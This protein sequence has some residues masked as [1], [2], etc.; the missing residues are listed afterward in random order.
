[1]GGRDWERPVAD[2]VIGRS[3]PAGRNDDSRR[4]LV[5]GSLTMDPQRCH[6]S[7]EYKSH[8][9]D[10]PVF[11][12]KWVL[13]F[14]SNGSAANNVVAPN[15]NR[16]GWMAGREGDG[17]GS[18][19]IARV[20]TH[21][22]VEAS[23]GRTLRERVH[24]LDQGRRR[25]PNGF[26]LWNGGLVMDLSWGRKLTGGPSATVLKSPKTRDDSLI[27]HGEHWNAW[28]GK[29]HVDSAGCFVEKAQS[30]RPTWDVV[31]QETVKT[32]EKKPGK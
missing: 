6:M 2:A 14:P 8:L 27:E 17:W 12:T 11:T 31:S 21:C 10:M 25:R 24:V 7:K 9:R 22:E 1:M 18:L 29:R 19:C 26:R 3:S 13:L 15:F 4:R 30:T 5:A 28:G 23:L 16:E 32:T 20:G